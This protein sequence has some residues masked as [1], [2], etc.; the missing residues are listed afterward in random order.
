MGLLVLVRYK[1]VATG[2]FS[3]NPNNSEMELANAMMSGVW[4]ERSKYEEAERVY[5]EHLAKA[6]GAHGD[7]SS[8]K[9]PSSDVPT[10]VVKELQD[11]NAALKT[12]IAEMSKMMAALESRL[13]AVESKCG[14]EK[15]AANPVAPAK[16]APA[17]D[18]DDDAAAAKIREERLAAYAAKKSKK[19]AVVVKSNIIFDVKPWDDETDMAELER[20]VRSVKTDGLLWGTSKLVKI[21]FGIQKLQITCVVEDD[22]VGTDFLEES[23][24]AFEDYVQSVDIAAF[25]KI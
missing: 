13:S 16:S 17:A 1:L 2:K 7:A 20:C 11:E 25:N 24:T 19:A 14:V 6:F 21:A 5:Q 9:V 18:D 3:S 22:K 4:T 23:I 15:P 10:A 12:Q 8:T